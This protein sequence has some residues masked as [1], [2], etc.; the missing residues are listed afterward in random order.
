MYSLASWNLPINWADNALQAFPEEPAITPLSPHN[1]ISTPAA[2]F[3]LAAGWIWIQSKGGFSTRDLW[4]RLIARYLVGLIGVFALYAGLGSIFPE[5][6]TLLSYLLRYVR[7]ALIGFWI[8][9]FAPWLFM[10]LKLAT[11]SPPLSVQ[12]KQAG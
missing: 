10:Q 3:G 5:T 7:Y 12:T 8:S 1:T 9:G 11:G 6:E 2:L 4:W